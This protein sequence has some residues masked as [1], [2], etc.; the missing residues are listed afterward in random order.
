M[1][2]G[3]AGEGGG[4]GVGG[5]FGLN[6]EQ[7]DFDQFVL[8]MIGL[9]VSHIWR[10]YGSALFV[11]FGELHYV[12][13]RNGKRSRNPYGQM[14]LS[15]EWSWRIEGKKRIWCGS[16]SDDSRWNKFFFKMMGAQ[17]SS[18]SLFGRLPEVDLEL[19]NGMH[20]LSLMTA[21]G[22]PEWSIGDHRAE[23]SRYLST[24]AGRLVIESS[25]LAREKI[26]SSE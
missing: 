22:D 25:S 19:S 10:G 2:E 23:R 1:F 21:E 9:P 14:G 17:V 18:I 16:W 26:S 4:V 5:S 11:E 20:L 12:L 6:T 24:K 7:P 13:L 8:P 3:D 15:I